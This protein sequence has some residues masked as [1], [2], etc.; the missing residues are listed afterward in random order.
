MQFHEYITLRTL[1]ARHGDES[2][3]GFARKMNSRE[4]REAAL[5]WFARN[6]KTD[7]PDEFN[8]GSFALAES[9]WAASERPYY[10]VWPIAVTLSASVKLDLRFSQVALPFDAMLLRFAKGHEPHHLKTALLFWPKGTNAIQVFCLF[11]DAKDSLL[12]VGHSIEGDAKVEEWLTN[13]Q[14]HGSNLPDYQHAAGLLVVRLVVFISLLAKGDDLITP[15]VLAKDQDKYEAA[16]DEDIKRWLAN[17]AARRGG[18]GFDVGKKLQF[19]RET[20][21]HWRN[22]HLCLF[23]TGEGR[24]V[25]VLKMRSGAV[26][27]SVSMADVP[28]GLFGAENEAEDEL[29]P[30]KTPREAVGRRRRFAIFRRDGYRCQLC[31]ASHDGKTKL[32]VDHKVPLAKGGSNEDDNLWTLCEDCNLGKSD[33]LL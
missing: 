20:S 6:A 15:I 25:P 11:G 17:R 32:H 8:K 14:Q 12:T 28:T 2:Q 3:K 23:W 10:N 13:L 27:Q 4:Y 22:P 29:G 26:I 30:D 16:T 18:R 33:A 31:G 24:N 21:P 1:T 9:V 7:D 19:A 5:E